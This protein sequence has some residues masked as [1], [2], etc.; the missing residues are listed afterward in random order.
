MDERYS[1]ASIS[2]PSDRAPRSFP[3][4]SA[5]PPDLEQVL[6]RDRTAI[7]QVNSVIVNN[8]S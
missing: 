4:D 2:L 5:A 3:I 1:M 7:A 6:V 8:S